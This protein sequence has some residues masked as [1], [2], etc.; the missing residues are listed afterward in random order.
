MDEIFLTD[1]AFIGIIVSSVEVF[2][3]ECLGLILGYKES[4][5]MTVEYAIPF[6]SAKR[7]KGSVE[8][9]VRRDTMC[10]ELLPEL[11][12]L[13]QLGYYHSHT[14][15]GGARA[16]T[17]PSKEDLQSMVEG[18][19]DIILAV[20][21]TKRRKEWTMDSR[22]VL[23]GTIG[24]FMFAFAAYHY[25]SQKLEW[26]RVRIVC[27]YAVGFNR[28]LERSTNGTSWPSPTRAGR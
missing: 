18:S 10:K 3:N 1:R 27:P 20:N 16:G 22:G 19:I 23:S 14:Q 13:E 8:A 25:H 24:E 12:H 11:S 2:R 15:Y 26:K 28:A 17:E 7:K 21:K 6:Q 9:N 4:D 5:R